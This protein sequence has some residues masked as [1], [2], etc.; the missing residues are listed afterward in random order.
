[1]SRDKKTRV[2]ARARFCF[3]HTRACKVWSDILLKYTRMNYC[4]GK[5]RMLKPN[6]ACAVWFK[7]AQ[8]AYALDKFSDDEAIMIYNMYK[9]TDPV[10]GMT[11]TLSVAK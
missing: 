2:K 10:R 3:L 4:F 7:H 1:M 9:P 6:C 8:F 11:L 5:L